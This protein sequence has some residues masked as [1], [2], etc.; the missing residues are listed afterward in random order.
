MKSLILKIELAFTSLLFFRY[1]IVIFEFFIKKIFWLWG[2]ARFGALVTNRKIGCVCH[3]SAELKYPENLFCGK[4]VVIGPEVVVGALSRVEL[5]DDV[6]ISKG[7]LIETATLDFYGSA[8]LPYSHIS[9]PI[10]IED[11]VWIG[12]HSIILGGVRIGKRSIV[13]AGSVVTKTIP[14]D[15]VVGGNPARVIKSGGKFE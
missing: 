8:Q 9:H 15:T 4:N 14:A 2:R 7:V 1:I 5:G 6:R 12:A 10:F 13:A 11:G 3:W